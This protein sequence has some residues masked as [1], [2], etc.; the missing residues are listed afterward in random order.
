MPEEILSTREA[1]RYIDEAELE[2]SS[3]GFDHPL[4]D[5]SGP[6]EE[7]GTGMS[8]GFMADVSIHLPMPAVVASCLTLR[9]RQSGKEKIILRDLS[10][11]IN[12]G[13]LVGVIGASGSGKSTF[14]Q[15]ISGIRSLSAGSV[16][17][18]GW[19][20]RLLS[21][22]LP[23]VIGYLPQ[24]TGFHAELSVREII[25]TAAALRLPRS[26]PLTVRENWAAHVVDV[27]GLDQLLDQPYRTLSGGQMRRMALAE[28]L[29]G[30]PQF[31]I[32]DELTSGLDAYSDREMMEWMRTLAH[33]H[34]K[35]VLIVTHATNHLH[36][37]D[38]VLFLHQGRLAFFGP[39]PALLESHGVDSVADLFG[40][41]HRGEYE[42]SPAL[43]GAGEGEAPRIEA[44]QTLRTKSPPSGIWQLPTLL[45]RQAVLFWRDQGQLWLQ[46]TLIVTFPL[47]VA[48]FALHGLPQVRNLNL[49]LEKNLVLTLE[50]SLFYLKESFHAASLI[51]GLAMFQVILLALMGA[52]NGAREIAKERD[53][54]QKEL[55][56][57]LSSSAYVTVKS[58]QLVILSCIQAFWMAW[59]VKVLC[60][61]PGD[62]GA[63][64]G[65]LFA[66]TLA[67][68]TAC[69]AISA[70][71]TTPER[72]S[73]LSIYLVGF[74]LPLSGAAIAL[75]DWLGHICRPFIVAYWGW[76]GYLQTFHSTRYYDIIS[77]STH[78]AI[79][80]YWISIGV[81]V[82]HSILAVGLTG[83]FVE[84]R[85]RSS[86]Y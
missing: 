25:G 45:R 67:M 19:D 35:T 38:S 51:S 62:I 7:P 86:K 69:L 40:A 76:S 57:G 68:S 74:Q 84:R 80:D 2:L 61:F 33:K 17:L 83:Y 5:P 9:V 16:S 44:S 59:F 73:L 28:A 32:L 75:P 36:L 37:C 77:Q 4:A 70:A 10:V 29:I 26:V 8:A 53:I 81:L 72:A 47:L 22:K 21:A 20:V 82:F 58:L 48:V 12:G 14:V 50:D 56:A 3:S 79:A 49:S 30:D 55:R 31:L 63:Q 71:T 13:E 60:G 27:S 18:A 15:A 1:K 41:Y 66:A 42:A 46:V 24:S 64:F 39:Y 43:P 52:N 65:I 34:A 78:T 85:R 6:D 11:S 54:L 23:L